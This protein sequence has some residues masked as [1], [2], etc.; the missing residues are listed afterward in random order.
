M[1]RDKK[2]LE[3]LYLEPTDRDLHCF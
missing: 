1:G 3:L 2:S